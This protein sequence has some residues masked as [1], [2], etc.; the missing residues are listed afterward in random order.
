M[1]SSTVGLPSHCLPSSARHGSTGSKQHATPSLEE[2]LLHWNHDVCTV[3]SV[4]GVPHPAP[5]LLHQGKGMEI[6]QS[7]SRR[8]LIRKKAQ[9]KGR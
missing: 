4:Q 7:K 1:G 5:L 2:L 3:L 8:D 9:S 6:K